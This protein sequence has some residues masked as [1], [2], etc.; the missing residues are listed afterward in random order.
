MK[1]MIQIPCYNEE[2]TLPQTLQDLPR[3]APGLDRVELLVIDDRKN[4]PVVPF[5]DPGALARA[6]ESLLADRD[7]RRRTGQRG[8]SEIEIHLTWD[9]VY[10]GLRGIYE[11]LVAAAF[12]PQEK[13]R[14]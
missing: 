6:I 9:R 7:G 11:G 14:I 5:G 13:G 4:G 1:L 10:E 2:E 12:P 3:D 8:S